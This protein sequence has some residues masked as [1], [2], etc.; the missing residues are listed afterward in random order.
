LKENEEA[1]LKIVFAQEER[2]KLA[3]GKGGESW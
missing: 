1:F 2:L 3:E